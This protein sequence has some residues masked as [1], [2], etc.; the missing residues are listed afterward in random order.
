MRGYVGKSLPQELSLSQ[1]W[2]LLLLTVWFQNSCSLVL[3]EKQA[4]GECSIREALRNAPILSARAQR[5]IQDASTEDCS[6]LGK[7]A[8]S[9]LTLWDFVIIRWRHSLLIE[10][11]SAMTHKSLWD[12]LQTN[13]KAS[14]GRTAA[15]AF[16]F[17]NAWGGS[18]SCHSL[19]SLHFKFT[20]PGAIRHGPVWV[21]GA[22]VQTSLSQCQA[23]RQT[24]ADNLVL[25]GNEKNDGEILAASLSSTPQVRGS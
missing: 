6:K 17:V 25:Y 5:E 3:G 13:G 2:L 4:G 24:G 21:P 15:T 16:L 1:A 18:A 22:N 12:P 8:S 20:L 14:T 7:E 19:C 9:S 10:K 23:S 11:V